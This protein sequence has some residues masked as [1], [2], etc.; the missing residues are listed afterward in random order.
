[1]GEISILI[2]GK[3][4]TVELRQHTL[5]TYIKLTKSFEKEIGTQLSPTSGAHVLKQ[6]APLL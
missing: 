5:H 6:G 2:A 3:R 1:M 4:L